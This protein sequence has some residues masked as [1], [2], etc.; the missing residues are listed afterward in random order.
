[1][2]RGGGAVRPGDRWEDVGQISPGKGK[3]SYRLRETTDEI[4]GRIYRMV[5]IHSS[6][7]A[8]RKADSFARRAEKER[9]AVQHA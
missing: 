9:E 5:V 2:A 4:D 3:A 8:E 6:S 1:M 7:L